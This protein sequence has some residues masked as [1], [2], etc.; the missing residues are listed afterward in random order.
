MRELWELWVP[1]TGNSSLFNF[2]GIWFCSKNVSDCSQWQVLWKKIH[3]S[4][5]WS[6]N[7]TCFSLVMRLQM[8]PQTFWIYRL[9]SESLSLTKPPFKIIHQY[10]PK[11][12]V[13]HHLHHFLFY[14]M[15]LDGSR[16]L[17]AFIAWERAAW[18]L[19]KTSAFVFS[20][21]IQGLEQH[22]GE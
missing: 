9:H 11:W 7:E 12:K 19:F 5:F 6:E 22:E 4:V 13:C 14:F 20:K 10:Y 3:I 1:L 16:S 21:I 2:S 8:F 17:Y 15:E 18:T